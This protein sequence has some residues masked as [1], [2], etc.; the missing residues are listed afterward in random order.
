MKGM[1]NGIIKKLY[2]DNVANEKLVHK[3]KT[4]FGGQDGEDVLLD[5]L[6]FCKVNQPTYIPGDPHTSAFNEGMRRVGLRLLSL[7]QQEKGNK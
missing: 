6:K 3:Y 5:I 2:K 1:L 4:V 7:T